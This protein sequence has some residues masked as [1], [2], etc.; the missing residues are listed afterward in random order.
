MS[1]VV[2]DSQ[3]MKTIEHSK[4]K[5]IAYFGNEVGPGVIWSSV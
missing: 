5:M 1:V 3:S 2:M 4:N